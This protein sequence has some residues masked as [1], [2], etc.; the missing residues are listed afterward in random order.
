MS[1]P[2][3]SQFVIPAEPGTFA[4]YQDHG[5]GYLMQGGRVIAW[6]IERFH[7]NGYDESA[8]TIVSAITA[9]GHLDGA[10]FILMPDGSVEGR[11]DCYFSLEHAN[12]PDQCVERVRRE[13][14]RAQPRPALSF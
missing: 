10:D 7:D 6:A 14:K 2:K 3:F 1:T 8:C 5:G 13:E 9:H 4:L 12:A 11:S